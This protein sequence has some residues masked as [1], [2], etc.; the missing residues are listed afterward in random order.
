MVLQHAYAATDEAELQRAAEGVSYFYRMFGTWFANR[1][2]PVNG[3]HMD[4]PP[5]D[6]E[7]FG[8]YAP[9]AVRKNTL[10]GTPEEL[11]ERLKGYEALG[12]DEY[13]I[14]VD[15][16]QLRGQEG[17]RRTLHFRH[18]A[19]LCRN[20]GGRRDCGGARSTGLRG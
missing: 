19:R 7:K 8:E 10:I 17:Q 9:D 15:L 20:G 16:A 6:L 3:F 1:K 2:P 4:I 11:I 18:P 14:W 12:I 13:S 5:L